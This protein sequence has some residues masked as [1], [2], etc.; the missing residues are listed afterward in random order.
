MPDVGVLA[1][2]IPIDFEELGSPAV[3]QLCRKRT[4]RKPAKSRG[5]ISP[6]AVKFDISLTHNNHRPANREMH[7]PGC[8]RWQHRGA[9]WEPGSK[10]WRWIGTFAP[11]GRARIG[12]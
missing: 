11:V 8:L 3:V 9:Q 12:L 4:G 1:G 7:D 6:I 10:G 2:A 5:V